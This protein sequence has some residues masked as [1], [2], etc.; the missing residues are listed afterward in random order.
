MSGYIS[1]VPCISGE[2]FFSQTDH[3]LG[4]YDFYL[5]NISVRDGDEKF[6]KR[7]V[8]A[9]SV[10]DWQDTDLLSQPNRGLFRVL[11]VAHGEDYRSLK[12]S[13]YIIEKHNQGQGGKNTWLQ[14]CVPRKNDN[15]EH[16]L[17]NILCSLRDGYEELQSVRAYSQVHAELERLA[18]G[19]VI[20]VNAISGGVV[21]EVGFET[22]HTGITLSDH[23][24][25]GDSNEEHDRKPSE[26]R[27][28]CNQAFYYLKFLLHKHVHHSDENEAL[29]IVH[30]KKSSNSENAD[31]LLRDLKRGLAEVKRSRRDVGYSASGIA[32]Y[33]SALANTCD[34]LGWFDESASDEQL[35]KQPFQI[36]RS[37]AAEHSYFGSMN[38]S[39][40]TLQDERIARKKL[41]IT[42]V[43]VGIYT[44]W[45]LWILAIVGPLLVYINVFSNGV[46]SKQSSA[47][48]NSDVTTVGG[49]LPQQF[50]AYGET[51]CS[52]NIPFVDLLFATKI[53]NSLFDVLISYSNGS[54]A[55]AIFITIFVLVGSVLLTF[56]SINWGKF[57]VSKNMK[58]IFRK[59]I[60]LT[61]S[62]HLGSLK[63]KYTF[64]LFVLLLRRFAVFF[65][66]PKLNNVLTLQKFVLAALICIW[67]IV[68]YAA[69]VFMYKGIAQ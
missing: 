18:A 13:I 22:H 33:G 25:S 14:R 1:W 30:K 37:L 51:V 21:H 43:F 24:R 9:S 27:V 53:C 5:S 15:A 57:E 65:Y 29:T 64:V 6:L 58:Q 61:A 45:V 10:V 12:G 41:S 7:H 4:S 8:I 17:L 3:G 62:S 35:N 39:L 50:E 38:K 60:A 36:R 28:L 26:K 55:A 47:N 19:T 16:S 40:E 46:M 23:I 20:S 48:V 68:L 42:S 44:K 56:L 11:L 54:V 67:V 63:P 32:A 31:A 69:I 49:G 34:A 66:R 52:L 2:L 59:R